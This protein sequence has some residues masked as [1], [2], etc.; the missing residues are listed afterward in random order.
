MQRATL[1]TSSTEDIMTTG[2]VAQA[3][4]GGE[5]RQHLVAVHLRHL[6]VEQDQVDGALAGATSSASRPFSA[7]VTVCPSCSRARPEEQAVH[8]VVVDDEEVAGLGVTRRGHVGGLQSA[9]AAAS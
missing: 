5:R 3:R 9:R 2:H 7:K 6:D 8:P 1:S 4:V